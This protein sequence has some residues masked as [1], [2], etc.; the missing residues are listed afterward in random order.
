MY[1]EKI[2]KI[3]SEIERILTLKE[4]YEKG[5]TP[6]EIKK[7]SFHI[8]D[9]YFQNKDVLNKLVVSNIFPEVVNVSKIIQ[10][11][12]NKNVLIKCL[13]I[14]NKAKNVDEKSCIDACMHWYHQSEKSASKI[15]TTWLLEHDKFQLSYY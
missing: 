11:I 5:Y 4:L 13:K 15:I 12:K 8:L 10:I 14:Y 1:E 2:Q 7:F 9:P 6:E 3:L